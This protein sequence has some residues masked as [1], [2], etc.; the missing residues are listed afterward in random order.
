[1]VDATAPLNGFNWSW[2]T[3][4][5]TVP[6]LV[7][8]VLAVPFWVKRQMTFGTVVGAGVIFA[9]AIGLILRE[10]VEL[11]AIIQKCFEDGTVCFPTPTAFT[12]FATYSFIALFEVMAL[13]WLSMVVEHR[14]RN[15][16]YSPE[17]R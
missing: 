14:V 9:F 10:H 4:A 17:W 11:D 8:L 16:D 1:M 6:F 2:I 7:G 13:F 15:R 5:S 12:R 3:L